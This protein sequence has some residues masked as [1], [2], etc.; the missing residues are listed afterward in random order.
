[1]SENFD[2]NVENLTEQEYYDIYSS[3]V[4]Y[5]FVED[6]DANTVVHLYEDYECEDD[7]VEATRSLVN[8]CFPEIAEIVER[9]LEKDTYVLQHY[10]NEL[11]GFEDFEAFINIET[12]EDF[13]KFTELDFFA[14]KID[15]NEINKNDK[16]SEALNFPVF[17]NY[18]FSN[19]HLNDFDLHYTS[20]T[21][22][23][24]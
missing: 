14:S 3:I 2:K 15:K 12:I 10:I 1:M 4:D 11:P 5:Y 18:P 23:G 6:Y 13:I 9:L 21:H 17:E 20:I 7:G 24:N 22:N 19:P 8:E 16:F